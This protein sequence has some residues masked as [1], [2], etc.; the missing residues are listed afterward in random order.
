MTKIL[1][2]I[3]GL[4]LG[5]AETMLVRLA[6]GLRERGHPQHVVSLNGCGALAGVLERG[7]VPVTDLGLGS[8]MGGIDGLMRL[9]RVIEATA[10]DLMQGW[11]YH[12]NLA[13]TAAHFVTGHR[14]KRNLYWNL[15]ASNMD[16]GRYGSI[17]RWNARLSWLADGIV[18]NSQ[19]GAAFHIDQGFD[20]QRF[21]VILNGID[22][23]KFRPDVSA[24]SALRDAQGISQDTVLVIHVARVD[25]MKDHETFLQ[26]MASRPNIRAILVGADTERLILPKNVCAF[27]MRTDPEKIYPAGDIVLSSSAFGEGF[28][29][30]LAEGM[31]AGLVPI[32]TDVGDTRTIVGAVGKVVPPRDVAVFSCALDEIAELEPNRRRQLGL[33]ARRRIVDNFS[34]E[35]AIDNYERLY[36]RGA[37]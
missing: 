13:A 22:T 33:D 20:A 6:I 16:S 23:D 35:R 36:L 9:R 7:G 24:R 4:G 34:I 10:P 18:V 32:G 14:A 8:A 29:N 3:S 19:A 5:G 1:H 37:D 30:T 21:A 25:P 28:S 2:V 31:S 11:M 17:I 15:R 27:G 12:G 26:A